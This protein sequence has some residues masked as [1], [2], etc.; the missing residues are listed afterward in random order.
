MGDPKKRVLTLSP[1]VLQTAVEELAV[2]L[3]ERL[4]ANPKAASKQVKKIWKDYRKPLEK[5][6]G[7]EGIVLLYVGAPVEG[8]VL[9]RIIAEHLNFEVSRDERKVYFT[10]KAGGD[11][12]DMPAH[13]VPSPY[14][15]AIP[16]YDR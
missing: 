12:H 9:P 11:I 15:D 13:L 6:F 8:I 2:W 10:F 4:L 5:R 1:E 3:Q 14:L 16:R 7:K